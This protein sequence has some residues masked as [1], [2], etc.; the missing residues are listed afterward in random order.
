[1]GMMNN[2]TY[3]PQL[4]S[5]IEYIYSNCNELI[6]STFGREFQMSGNIGIFAQSDEEFNSFK[7]IADELT[8][9]SDN[10]N[11]KYFELKVPI[12][13]KDP[14]AEFTHLYV[15][16]FDPSEYGKNKGDIDFVTDLESYKKYKQEVVNSKYPEAQ[17]YDRPGWDTI[18]INKP[19]VDVV[20]YLTTT[21]FAR[22]VRVKFDNL[23]Q[24]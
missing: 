21:E 14:D 17:M 7:Q 6:K 20:A 18:Q 12:I 5:R 22:K 9:P 15:R 23:T 3:N 13:L 19:E 1:M 2:S 24:L 11:Q 10:A 16:K 4:L 8:R